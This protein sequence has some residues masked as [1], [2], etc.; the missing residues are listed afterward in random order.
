[1]TQSLS[2]SAKPSIA[3]DLKG[4]SGIGENTSSDKILLR[5]ESI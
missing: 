2:F 3:E 5:Q 1:L 4:G